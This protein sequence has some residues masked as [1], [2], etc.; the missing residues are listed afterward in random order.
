MFDFL[1][2]TPNTEDRR[3]ITLA[4]EQ[5]CKDKVAGAYQS[6]MEDL[7]KLWKAP[8]NFV[9]GIG[10]LN[11]YGLS[12]DFVGAGTFTDQRAP[13]YRYQLSWGGPS[14]E[15]RIFLNGDVEFWYLDW[16]DGASV[17]VTGE[18]AET[19]KNIVREAYPNL[20]RYPDD[21]EGDET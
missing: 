15:F 16:F 5:K 6:R 1:F 18:D 14:E 21:Y 20:D 11:E 12:I 17:P 13:Y 9:D 10:Y 3:E 2:G 8:D 4:Q 19:I 7:R